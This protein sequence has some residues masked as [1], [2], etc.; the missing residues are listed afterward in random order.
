MVSMP[1][2]TL[3]P[4]LDTQAIE[5]ALSRE[6]APDS[7]ELRDILD[8]SLA[9]ES[10]GI[11]EAV[12]LMRVSDAEHLALLLHTAD[13]VKQKV[14]GDRIVLSAPLHISNYCGSECLYCANRRGNTA[15]ER[16]YM[17]PPEMREAGR[18][19]IRQG[20]KRVF[21]VSGQLPNADV[22]YL[23]EAVSVLY[24]A[25]DGV[26]EIRRVNINVGPLKAEEYALLQAADVGTVLIYQ[27]TYHEASYRAA[28]VSGPKSDYLARL[29]APDTAFQAGV[30]DVGL[31]LLLGLGPWRYDLL[32]VMLHAAH[33]TR[34]YDAG[35]RT[36]SMHRLRPTPG[37]RFKTP[38]PL[39]DGEY[40][41]CV[42]ITRLAVPYTGI[43]LTTKGARRA[44]AR[45]LQRGAARNCSPAAWPTRMR[46]GLK[47]RAKKRPFPSARIA[48]WTRWCA[49]CWKRPGTC[50]LSVRP[51]R[52]WA[53]AAM[54]SS[55][56]CR[57]AA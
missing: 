27:D 42:A 9:L 17:T 23:E 11:Q 8:K 41:R 21:L 50:L 48:M 46:A 51:V 32:A 35:S 13:Q 20:H 5:K 40:L 39:S 55:P 47:R 16:K 37:G 33:L 45:Q 14:Y 44:L 19:L 18:K 34:V 49:S 28:H 56:W 22:E 6:S 30:G 53:A 57:N 15:V 38:Y 10:L 24:T 1:T 25:F 7:A 54:N 29:H 31:G 43:V 12:A 26:G 36:V 4:W 3:P 2:D 52:V